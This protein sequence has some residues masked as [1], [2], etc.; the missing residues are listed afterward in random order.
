MASLVYK[1]RETR[2]ESS[3]I[4]ISQMGFPFVVVCYYLATCNIGLGVN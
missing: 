2:I 1:I 4:L 3:F